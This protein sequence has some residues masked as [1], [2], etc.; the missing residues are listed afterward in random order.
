MGGLQY[1]KDSDEWQIRVE[2]NVCVSGGGDIKKYMAWGC[3]DYYQ[4]Y[5]SATPGVLLL[6]TSRRSPNYVVRRHDD[7][8][9]SFLK[10]EEKWTGIAD[11]DSNALA[12]WVF[13]PS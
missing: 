3:G 13:S 8:S 10:D 2:D 4:L 9:P 1:W 7:G 6:A 11:A 5:P 12:H